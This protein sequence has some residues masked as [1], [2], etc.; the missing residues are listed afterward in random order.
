MVAAVAAR[1]PVNMPPTPIHPD[2]RL[3]P[4]PRPP[5]LAW[6]VGAAGLGVGIGCGV[7]VGVGAPLGLRGVPLVGDA[8]GGLAAGLGAVDGALGCLPSRALA[9]VEAAL[10]RTLP[11]G[12]AR[13]A[14]GA[15]CGVGVGYGYG[16]GLFLEP[17]A[18]RALQ[19]GWGRAVGRLAGGGLGGG[20][21]AAPHASPD[22]LAAATAR[23]NALESDVAALQEEAGRLKDAVCTLA[24]A[25]AACRASG[26]GDD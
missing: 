10:G 25:T 16:A 15:G 12:R 21:A 7:G 26:G 20:L 18:L 2:P 4:P 19:A 3:S 5:L 23:L 13:A 14:A 17:G 1:P 22:A 6:R 9:A 11:P 8:V 24:P